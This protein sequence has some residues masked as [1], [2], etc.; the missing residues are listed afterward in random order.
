MNEL[1]GM[2]AE[3]NESDGQIDDPELDALFANMDE[4]LGVDARPLLP[5]PE[6]KSCFGSIVAVVT[7]EKLGLDACSRCDRKFECHG[8]LIDSRWRLEAKPCFG[9]GK[10]NLPTIGRDK[11]LVCPFWR[12]CSSVNRALLN[13]T[14]LSFPRLN[15]TRPLDLAEEAPTP[16]EADAAERGVADPE[17][18]AITDT[19]PAASGRSTEDFCFPSG[20]DQ[21]EELLANLRSRESADLLAE[22]AGFRDKVEA[23][24]K[25]AYL[26]FRESICAISLVLNEQGKIGPRF[27]ESVT[28]NFNKGRP[29]SAEDV[30]IANDRRVIDLHWLARNGRPNSSADGRRIFIDGRLDFDAA[31]RFSCTM[32]IPAYSGRPFRSNP[33]IDSGWNRPVV[34]F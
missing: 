2:V 22:L 32:R 15:P 14:H 28:G 31:I 8:E 5:S 13:S 18:G 17:E 27:R 21:F 9:D 30:L 11:C 23:S 4:V 3:I 7:G 12:E 6:S 1:P 29:A 20:G 25:T 19:R 16:A 34:P 26:P 10:T 24:S 33:T